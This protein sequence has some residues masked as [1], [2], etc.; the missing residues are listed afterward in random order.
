MFSL[1]AHGF[2]TV[3]N[4]KVLLMIVCGVA[5]GIA[6]GALPG[7]TATMGVALL[8]P[9][10]F[11]MDPVSG[12]LLLLGIY[13]GA[14]YGGSI[15]AILLKTP[16]T[17]AAAATAMDGFEMAKRGEAGRA[18][19]ISTVSSFGG[20]FI[21]VILLIL[22][23]PQLA[24]V[25]LKFSAPEYFGLAM[26]GLSIIASISGKSLLKGLIAGV[27]G[28]IV[29][30]IGIDLVTGYP[31]FTFGN[32]NL[33]NGLSFIPVM[34]GL[35]ALSQAFS[36]IENMLKKV[37]IKQSVERVLPT[38]S[39]LKAI[40]PSVLRSGIIGTFIGIIPGAGGDIGAFVSYNEAKRF[41]KHP[42]KFGTGIPEA[43]AAPEAGNNGVTGGAM[44]PLLTLGIP[45][46]AVAAIMLGALIMQGLQP[47][48]LLF[49]D[50][51]PLVY[52]IFAGFL[53]ANVFMLILGLVGIRFFTKIIAIP[54]Y[55][56]TP[57]IFVLCIVGS[58]A[59]NNN[60]FDVKVMFISG[61][62]GYLMEKLEFPASPVVLA[63]ILGPMA[64]R[65]LR[66]ALIMSGGQI[67]VLFT[68]PISATLLIIATITLFM[69]II[70]NIRSKIKEKKDESKCL[71]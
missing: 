36:S 35:F 10:T 37:D 30:T 56:L 52:T 9:L 47:G 51:G 16:G 57:V 11:G 49:R 48:P 7:L 34:I 19:G 67:S 4:F 29:S 2:I 43:I 58:Y 70:K 8:L 28:L 39:D 69:P 33:F 68:R 1:L 26:F 42:E 13:A 64:E 54:S 71:Q 38:L 3:L 23:S 41:S 27:V 66:K 22:I 44:V 14:I 55:I 15:S 25:A 63:L 59:I 20:G 40:L 18:L 45:G 53:M 21:S 65:E 61:I 24:K 46:D 32:I 62:I 5:A 50:H 12:I 17:P 6:I 60:F 31:R